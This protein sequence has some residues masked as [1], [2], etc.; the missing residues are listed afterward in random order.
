MGLLSRIG[1]GFG[2]GMDI[3]GMGGAGLGAAL[4]GVGAAMQ[5]G[6]MNDV[7]NGAMGGAIPGIA[8]GAA[9]GG[10]MGAAGGGIK[11]IVMQIAQM[12]KQ[13]RPDLPDELILQEAQT[14]AGKRLQSMYQRTHGEQMP[15][16]LADLHARNG[17]M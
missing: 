14:L 11:G 17:G 6:D 9:L 2:R 1:N 10:M 3:G 12:L 15:G 13:Q 5:G 16:A 7:L 8:G 4:G